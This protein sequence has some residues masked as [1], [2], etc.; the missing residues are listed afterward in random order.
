VTEVVVREFGEPGDLGWAVMANGEVCAQ[1]FGWD[2]DFEALVA[3]ILLRF[4]TGAD[5][6]R[7]RG[8]IA[9]LGGRR[10]GCVFV[11]AADETTA[12]LRVL[13][14]HPEGRG[15]GIGRDLVGRC[16]AFARAA[17]YAR[18]VLWTNDLQVTAISIYRRAGFRLTAQQPHHSWGADLVGQTYELSLVPKGMAP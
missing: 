9:T 14:V 7:E 11:T 18:I 8:W 6:R 4:V 3:Q 13:L 15:R 1:E 2:M 17:G 10:V 12:Q 5:R 16:I